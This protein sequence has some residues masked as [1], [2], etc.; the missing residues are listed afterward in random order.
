MN[1]ENLFEK[2]AEYITGTGTSNTSNGSYYVYFTDIV[3]M[4]NVTEEWVREHAEDIEEQFD[5]D[6]VAECDIDDES[7]GMMFYLDYCCE[8]CSTY[9]NGYRCYE[10][11][12]S[13][14]C[15]CDSMDE[16]YKPEEV[17]RFDEIQRENLKVGDVVYVSYSNKVGVITEIIKETY[18]T[19]YKVNGGKYHENFVRKP[20]EN[21]LKWY[22]NEQKAKQWLADRQKELSTL[23][24]RRF[25]CDL[26]RE[27]KE[28]LREAGYFVYDLRDW[29]EGN[30]YNIEPHVVVNH[31]GCWVTDM[32]LIPYMND[33]SGHWIGIDELKLAQIEEI[34]YSEIKELLDKGKELHFKKG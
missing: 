1:N 6:V 33:C 26:W 30:G 19:L 32:D 27:Q 3:K 15:W 14:D 22:N 20:T 16:D 34:P 12:E 9:I 24:F 13:C 31:I 21:E 4:F 29:D 11:C 17:E 2:I 18:C 10:E 7:F 23:K 8:K 25:D 28:L 5:W